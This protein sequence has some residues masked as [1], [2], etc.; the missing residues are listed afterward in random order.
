MKTVDSKLLL[1]FCIKNKKSLTPTRALIIN[2]LA[3][4]KKPRSAYDIQEEINKNNENNINISTIYRVL[5]FWIELGLVHKISFLN[6]FFLCVKPDEKHTHMINICTECEAIFE[7][8]N[9]EMGLNFK[10]STSKFKLSL[11]NKHS[12]EVPVLCESCS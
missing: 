6:K 11:N 8:C 1:N 7:T 5:E 10:K 4:H 12:I 3:N 9:E 2:L